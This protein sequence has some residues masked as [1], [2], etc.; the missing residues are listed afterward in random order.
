MSNEESH[1]YLLIQHRPD[2]QKRIFVQDYGEHTLIHFREFYLPD[3]EVEYR[4]GK[5]GIT[6]HLE[7]LDSIIE[8]LEKIREDRDAGK[9]E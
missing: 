7:A 9:F 5:A 4:H 1:E 8:A 3:E 2:A 6:F